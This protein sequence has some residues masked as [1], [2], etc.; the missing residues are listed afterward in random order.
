MANQNKNGIL[1][2]FFKFFDYNRDNRPDALEEDTTPTVKRYFKVLGRRFWKLISLNL[3][4]L[5]MII[6]VL[7]AIYVYFAMNQTPTA[8][9]LLKEQKHPK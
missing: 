4:M 8:N 2:K 6:P 7:I 3:M 1:G 5:P 9:T